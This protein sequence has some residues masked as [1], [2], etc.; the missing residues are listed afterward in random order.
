MALS[1]LKD[2]F[3]TTPPGQNTLVASVAYKSSSSAFRIL[4]PQLELECAGVCQG[5]RNFK[6]DNELYVEPKKSTLDFIDY[7]CCNCSESV[8]MYAL[9]VV[10][11]ENNKDATFLKFGEDPPF[12]TSTPNK[13]LAL[14]GKD[15]NY[16]LKGRQCE[17][18]GLGIGAFAYY[19]RVV[20]SH[21]NQ[22]ID[23]IIT[24]AREAKADQ[25]LLVELDAAKEEIQFT[26]SIET[27]KKALPESLLVLGHNPL[28]LLHTCLSDG[29]H[30]QTDE[31]CLQIATEIRTVLSKLVERI[32]LARQ[33]QTEFKTAISRLLNR[34]AGNKTKNPTENE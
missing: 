14:F 5:V 26:T 25:G 29:M 32:T 22:I 17:N 12:G 27:I 34:N 7:S 21:K 20:E 33:E 19:R 1:A 3:Q 31:K 28:K 13:V 6:T 11:A 23:E 18:Q 16:F 24:V 9:R 15:R 10:L 30:D 8:K 4:L 2:F